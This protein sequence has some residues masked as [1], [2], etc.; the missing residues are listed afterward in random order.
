VEQLSRT[1]E[2]QLVQYDNLLTVDDVEKGSKYFV[3][4]VDIILMVFFIIKFYPS[5]SV[6]PAYDFLSMTFRYP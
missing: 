6:H 1:A 5:L 4:P 3:K 2:N